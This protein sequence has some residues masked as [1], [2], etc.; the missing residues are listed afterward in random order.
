MIHRN[1]RARATV[2]VS[3]LAALL[4]VVFLFV[5]MNEMMLFFRQLLIG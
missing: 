1:Q 4:A 5:K 3:L 2:V